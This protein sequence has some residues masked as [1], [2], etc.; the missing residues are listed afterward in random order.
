MMIVRSGGALRAFDF[1]LREPLFLLAHLRHVLGMSD[2]AEVT[3][4]RIEDQLRQFWILAVSRSTA[5]ESPRCAARTTILARNASG[6]I[7]GWVV[8]SRLSVW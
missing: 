6:V 1:T 3:W 5:A 2:L 4:Q 7:S 8:V